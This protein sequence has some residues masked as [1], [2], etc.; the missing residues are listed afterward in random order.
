MDWACHR[1][2]VDWACHRIPVG[3]ACHTVPVDRACRVVPVV[4]VVCRRVAVDGTC[5]GV[6]LNMDPH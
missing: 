2:P 1:T 3:R 4:P 5:A 6:R